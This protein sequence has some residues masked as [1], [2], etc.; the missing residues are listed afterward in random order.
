MKSTALKG[1][2]SN[3]N[4]CRHASHLYDYMLLEQIT[5][6]Q[7]SWRRATVPVPEVPSPHGHGWEV[8]NASYEVKFVWLG[9]KPA[10]EEVLELLSCTCKRVCTL[11]DCCCLKA[12]LRCTDLC[13]IQCDNME[14]DDGSHYDIHDD[15][16]PEDGED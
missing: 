9:S 8:D 7:S 10:P 6:Q 16:E 5:K 3:H 1:E 15:S 2:R 4:L 13:S 11:R 14:T 12:G